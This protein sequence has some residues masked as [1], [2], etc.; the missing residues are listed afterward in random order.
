MQFIFTV[1]ISTDCNLWKFI[2][3][4]AFFSI[5]VPILLLHNNNPNKYAA[6]SVLLLVAGR[7]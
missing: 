1:P 5:F 4:F 6:N 7:Q 2:L 3:N